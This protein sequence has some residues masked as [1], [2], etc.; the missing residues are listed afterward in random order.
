MIT[1]K[2][3]KLFCEIGRLFLVEKLKEIEKLN[4]D[5]VKNID[6]KSSIRL[7]QEEVE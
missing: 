4:E 3:I 7:V 6:Q 1:E 5:R 2:T